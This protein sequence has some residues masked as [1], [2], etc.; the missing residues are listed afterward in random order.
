MSI[1]TFIVITALVGLL[2]FLV[3]KF[4]PMPAPWPTV[5]NVGAGIIY[6]VW[7]LQS[8]GILNR[9]GVVHVG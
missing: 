3:N 8:F 1:V 2:L 4:I 7:L 5:L 6:V 9:L